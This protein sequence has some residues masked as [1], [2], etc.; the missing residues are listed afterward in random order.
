MRNI[1]VIDQ[2]WYKSLIEDCES[3]IV[4]KEFEHRI[5]LIEGYHQ[6]GNRILQDTDKFEMGTEQAVQEVALAI[7]KSRRTIMYAVKFAKTY[8]DLN[9]LNEGKNI[10]W[11][12]IV[13]K[14][15]TEPTEPELL[16]LPVTKSM[17]DILIKNASWLVETMKQSKN[18]IT[19]FLP[20]ERI[21]N[22]IL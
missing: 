17:E 9:L 14:H 5:S 11:S 22:E 13:R 20:N 18:G 3:I 21:E 1:T 10:T 8:P 12:K 7:K 2:D 4:E 15:L 19:F 16:P 6:L